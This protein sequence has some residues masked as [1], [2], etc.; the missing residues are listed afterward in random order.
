MR[1]RNKRSCKVP[2]CKNTTDYKEYC[3]GHLDRVKKYGHPMEDVP[4]KVNPPVGHS[5]K[6]EVKTCDRHA[7]GC[8]LC[9]GH[10]QRW[11]RYGDV[12][13]DIPI[14]IGKTFPPTGEIA[15]VGYAW[16]TWEKHYVPREAF[17]KH[18]NKPNG[19]QSRCK[20]C[21]FEARIF[22]MYGITYV[23]YEQLWLV[24]DGK[25]ALCKKLETRSHNGVIHRLCI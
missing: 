12:R 15:P 25:C 7:A 2:T 19:L 13:E 5:K 23:R 20:D 11:L 8:G 21:A 4:L 14:G 1:K 17:S 10:Y 22:P 18:K 9:N 16:C 3:R 24:Q 6:C